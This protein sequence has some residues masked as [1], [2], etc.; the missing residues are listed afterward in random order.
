MKTFLT[1]ILVGATIGIAVLGFSMMDNH[2]GM[3]G[4]YGTCVAEAV[5]GAVCPANPLASAVFHMDAMRFF[6]TATFDGSIFAALGLLALIA[7]AFSK[8]VVP[9]LARP[10]AGFRKIVD[11]P[12]NQSEIRLRHWMA[13][14]ELS[15][16]LGS[17]AR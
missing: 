2:N 10:P 3:A 14:H 5:N 4:V 8:R 13:F 9:G 12:P 1:Y 11:A 6:S 16:P 15:P 7:P 17:T